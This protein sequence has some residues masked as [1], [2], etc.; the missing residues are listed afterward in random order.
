MLYGGHC[1]YV[2][3]CIN[4]KI[5][6]IDKDGHPI[7]GGIYLPDR[8]KDLTSVVEVLV[9]GP[10]I[11]QI[12]DKKHREKYGGGKWIASEVKIGDLL[13]CPNEHPGIRVSPLSPHE[14]FVE[15]NTPYYVCRQG[16]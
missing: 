13:M 2:R 4:G 9:V 7:V 11:S 1:Y 14:F 5:D 15:E 6:K 10:R 16:D 8:H 3:Q 12:R